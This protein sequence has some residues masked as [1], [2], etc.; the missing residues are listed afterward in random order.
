MCKEMS[1]IPVNRVVDEKRII[2]KG[3]EEE[4]GR[5]GSLTERGGTHVVSD[6]LELGDLFGFEPDVVSVDKM[7][8]QVVVAA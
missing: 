2:G 7:F 5:K 4:K 6:V 1:A 3:A 8:G